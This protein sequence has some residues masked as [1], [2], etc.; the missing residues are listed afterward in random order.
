MEL[1]GKLW[2]RLRRHGSRDRGAGGGREGPSSLSPRTAVVSDDSEL[3]DVLRGIVVHEVD[4]N[5]DVSVLLASMRAWEAGVVIVDWRLEDEARRLVRFVRGSADYPSIRVVALVPSDRPEHLDEVVELGCDDFL[6]LPI[7]PKAAAARLRLL[8]TRTEADDARRDGL[9]RLANRRVLEDRITHAISVARRNPGASFA[10]LFLGVDRFRNVNE[11]LGHEAGDLL[12]RRIAERLEQGTRPGD[13]AARF[14]SD[15]FVVLVEEIAETRDAVE[16]AQRLHEALSTPCDVGDQ[17]IFVTASIGIVL[18]Q[19]SYRDPGE[20]LRDAEIAMTRAKGSGRTGSAVFREDMRRNA[21]PMLKLENDLR[22]ALVGREFRPYYQPIVSIR[23][24]RLAGFEVLARWQHPERGLLPPAD[25][26]EVGEQTGAIIQMDRMLIEQA[27]RQ[28][29]VWHSRFRGLRH[30]TV[31]LNISTTQFMQH[32]L[33]SQIDLILR[34]T[35]LYGSS[36]K[37][38]VTESALMTDA[39]FATQMLEQ[40]RKLNIGISVDDFGT[41][42]SSLAYLKRFEV[43]TL[44]IDCSFVFKMLDDNESR[45]IVRSVASLA[46]NLGKDTVAEGVETRSQLQAL[47]KLGVDYAQGY[48]IAPPLAAD[49]VEEFLHRVGGVENH[50]EKMQNDR[51]QGNSGEAP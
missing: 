34:N 17:E 43:D 14:E 8:S 6:R 27:C 51:L 25:F 12:L 47:R 33:V 32:D 30:L 9:T 28:L 3:I 13:L 19:P 21:A 7:E 20:M 42:Y 31:S 22:R 24:G 49:R 50:L 48:Y 38:E 37:L 40:L 18:W 39:L 10:V 35:G 45:E 5:S 4:S 41:G 36:L 16:V 23:N 44:K 26:I 29:K 11:S 15:E 2:D 1:T 46:R